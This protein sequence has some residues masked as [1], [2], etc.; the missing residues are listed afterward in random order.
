MAT[1]VYVVT[2]GSYSDYSI[3]AVFLDKDAAEKYVPEVSKSLWKHPVVIEEWIAD[4]EAGKI[5]RKV[6]ASDISLHTGALQ[7]ISMG[8]ELD[9]PNARRDKVEF[10]ERT[11]EVRA[12]SYVSQEH[13][14][15]LCVEYRQGWL[16]ERQVLLDAANASLSRTRPYA[17]GKSGA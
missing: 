14:D 12:S 5:V 8:A 13:A 7:V 15:K 11:M 6:F 9:D 1:T 10:Y 3:D 2:S 4:A 17:A 16:R